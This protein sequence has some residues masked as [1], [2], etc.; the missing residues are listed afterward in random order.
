MVMDKF[1]G[2]F[3]AFYACYTDSGEISVE[4]TKALVDYFQQKGVNGL[5]VGGSSGE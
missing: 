5:Y 3:P 1:K 4:R 2:V